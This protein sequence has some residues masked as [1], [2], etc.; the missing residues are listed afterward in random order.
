MDRSTFISSPVTTLR[1]GGHFAGKKDLF[2]T[3]DK[4]WIKIKSYG[5]KSN[6]MVAFCGRGPGQSNFDAA[7][8]GKL[9]S[10]GAMFTIPETEK[11]QE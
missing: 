1:S 11:R 10:F 6:R 8:G 9:H 4:H 7:S 2:H 3:C 5:A